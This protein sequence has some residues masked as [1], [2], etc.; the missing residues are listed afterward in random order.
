MQGSD[1]D[2]LITYPTWKKYVILSSHIDKLRVRDKRMIFQIMR[3]TIDLSENTFFPSY[4]FT[5]GEF[6]TWQVLAENRKSRKAN[7]E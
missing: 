5:A 4:G 6:A 2:C 3:K 7:K 1:E